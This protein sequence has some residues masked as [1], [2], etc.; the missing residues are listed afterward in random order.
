MKWSLRKPHGCGDPRARVKP[1]SSSPAHSTA[2][3]GGLGIPE[4]ADPDPI[5]AGGTTSIRAGGEIHPLT[6]EP[7]LV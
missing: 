3:A 6:V 1:E 4:E 2:S 7:L 5:R